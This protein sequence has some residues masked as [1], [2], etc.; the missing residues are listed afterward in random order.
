[1]ILLNLGV[2]LVS[3]APFL[4]AADLLRLSGR[5]AE[6]ASAVAFAVHA[7]PRVKPPGI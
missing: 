4:P 6:G 3:L 1:L 2:W 7:W 5:L